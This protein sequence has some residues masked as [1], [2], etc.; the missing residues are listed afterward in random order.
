VKFDFIKAYNR[1]DRC[2]LYKTLR[3]LGFNK[4][5]IQLVSGLVE[6]AF[7]KVHFY[8][9]FMEQFSLEQGVR[10]GAL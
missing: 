9:L 7:G 5:F 6:Q 4:N 2:F 8:C 10:Q 3:A 1:V